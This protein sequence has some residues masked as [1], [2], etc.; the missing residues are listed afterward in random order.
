MSLNISDPLSLLPYQSGL[1]DPVLI[2]AAAQAADDLTAQQQAYRIGDPV[3]IVFCRR[4]SNNGGVLVSPGATEARYENDGVTNA[5]TV[6]LHLV[7]SEGELPTIPIKDV[8]VGPCRQGTWDQNY[9]RRS[10][11]WFPGNF[12]T[13]VSGKQPWSCPYYCGT[14]GRYEDMTTLSY[15]NT[16]VDGSQR[17]NQQVHAFVRE[18]IQITRIIDSTLGPSNNVIDLAIYLMNQSGRIPSTLID[19]A[20]M[21]AAANFCEVNE[22]FY[23]GVFSESQN[24]DSWLERTSN[25]FLLRLVE[26]DGKFG[27][28]PRLPVN[29]DQTIKTTA[30]SWV[31]TFTEDHLLPDG[32]EI[33]YIA[34]EDRLPVCLQMMWRQQPDADIGF[35]RTTEIRFTGEALAG[36]F[37]QYDLSQF[38]TSESH[39]VKVGAYRLARRKYVTH[40]LRLTVRPSSYN[41]TLTLGDVVRVR[42]RRETATTALDYHDYLYEVERIEKTASG[43]CVFDLTHLP[44]DGQGRSLVALE[45]ASATAPNVNISAGRSDYSCDDNSASDNTALGIDGIDYPPSGGN[46]DPPLFDWTAVGIDVPTDDTWATGGDPP[47]GP[48]VSLPSGSPSGG[49]APNGGWNNP[50]DPL[51]QP[52]GTD[53]ITGATGPGGIPQPSDVL[54]VSETNVGCP[55]QV[56]W[57]KINKNTLVETLISCQNE[58]IGGAWNLSITTSEID[59]FI[60]AVGRCKDPSTASGFGVPRTLGVVGPVEEFECFTSVTV[61]YTEEN[62]VSGEAGCSGTCALTGTTTTKSRAFSSPVTLIKGYEDVSYGKIS[63]TC[64][65]SAQTW[66]ELTGCDWIFGVGN[67]FPAASVTRTNG[68]TDTLILAWTVSKTSG[69]Y[70]AGQKVAY[71]FH[72]GTNGATGCTADQ[73]VINSVTYNNTVSCT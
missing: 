65:G 70:I 46:F 34:L 30:I 64:G 32:F 52:L 21:L 54:S 25:D 66:A 13:T 12:V 43:A 15:V 5:L 29:T 56:C 16:F 14:S 20:Q 63:T 50:S 42:L 22:L 18:G 37:E 17:W 51:E 62:V 68:V 3:P 73:Y 19:T 69:Q 39:A 9:D 35:A 4:A 49:P 11:T 40:T 47:I 45:V 7:L 53:I 67:P 6:S 72:T 28:K 48:N 57:F 26:T 27:F 44:I 55:G 33:Q 71:V 8:F 58:P 10:G 1:A 24:L 60:K 38:C 59:F 61:N 41:S 2:E 36:P 31:F 23:N